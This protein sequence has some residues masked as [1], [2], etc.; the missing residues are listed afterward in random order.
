MAFTDPESHTGRDVLCAMLAERGLRPDSF[1]GKVIFTGNHDRSIEAVAHGIVDAATVHGCVLELAK[2]ED[3]SL[4]ERVRTI[5]ASETF[6]P[7]PIVVPVTVD[8]GLRSSL[9]EAFLA[10]DKDQEGRAILAPLGISRFVEPRPEDY[11][12]AIALLE[13]LRAWEANP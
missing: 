5:W 2:R 13:R 3:K 7:P 12:S 6:G 11:T 9:R 1:F 10:L 8:A 4:G